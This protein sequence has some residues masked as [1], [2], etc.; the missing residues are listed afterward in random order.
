MKGVISVDIGSTSMRAVLYDAA[1]R[2]L[3]VAQR[4]SAPV[5]GAGGRVEQDA[6][7]WRDGLIAL[8]EACAAEA[9]TRSIEP[10]CVAVTA[11]RSSVLPVDAAGAPLHPALMWQDTR[12]AALVQELAGSNAAV[13]GRTGL[14]ISTVFSAIK[15]AWLRRH[16][17]AVWRATHK[18]LGVQDWVLWLLTGRFVTDH[19]LASRTN[20]LDLDRR[21]W[22]PDMLALFE[23][24]RSM[25]CDLVPPGSIVGG[26]TPAVARRTGLDAGLPVVSAGGDQQCAALGL[27]LLSASHAVANAG[28]GGYL[29]GHAERPLHDP[30]MRVSC[31]VS[32]VPGAYIVEAALL[33]AGSVHEWFRKLVPGAD[34][35]AL[36]DEAAAVS[37]GCDGVLLNTGSGNTLFQTVAYPVINPTLDDDGDHPV[38]TDLDGDGRVDV[39]VAQFSTRPYFL[40]NRSRA[41][42]M[43]LVEATPPEVPTG[44]IGFRNTSFDA[45]GDG[46][47]DVWL[48]LRDKNYLVLGSRPE[49]EPN[50]SLA[51]ADVVSTFPALLAGVLHLDDDDL[52]RLPAAV[53]AG[54][55]IRLKPSGGGD[56]RLRVL[57]AAGNVLQTSESG[58]ANMMEQIDVPAASGVTF[59]RVE[60][61]G[62][63]SGGVYRL[64]VLRPGT[65]LTE[66]PAQRSAAPVVRAPWP[67][68]R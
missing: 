62:A 31:N 20:L 58:G 1:G 37:P 53:S 47:P 21:E 9:R 60:R 66:A 38:A 16:V 63:T 25:L 51:A 7:A 56:L 4:A 50:G 59:A 54:A 29:I 8:L 35:R 5:Y 26:L 32:A 30:Q 27:G 12:G 68:G 34:A 44:V 43:Q 42:V 61:Q 19:S 39:V 2:S 17:P 22:A 33:A 10:A 13:Y 3:H 45:N 6:H 48:A 67:G 24:P 55:G 41:G 15:M 57:D 14:R 11:Q 18:L 65:P 36:E 28:T 52:F 49:R 64:E 46:V 23:V 40:M